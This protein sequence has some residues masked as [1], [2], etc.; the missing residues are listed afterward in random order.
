MP[1]ILFVFTFR[2]NPVVPRYL[3]QG[4]QGYTSHFAVIS[5]KL[6]S[7]F[8]D[9]RQQ[10]YHSLVRLA[11]GECIH[12]P[13]NRP[14]VLIWGRILGHLCCA[15]NQCPLLQETH[16]PLGRER[17]IVD[18]KPV[19]AIFKCPEVRLRAIYGGDLAVAVTSLAH[20]GQLPCAQYSFP[21]L[22]STEG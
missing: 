20:R 16:S 10:I 19:V 1:L 9:T 6:R 14:V 4:R 12:M 13:I 18:T 21:R 7:S 2:P 17:Y 3:I 5:A 11:K 15:A 8:A 22:F